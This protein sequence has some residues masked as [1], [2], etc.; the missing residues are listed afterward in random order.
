MFFSCN[1]ASWGYFF[2][3]LDSTMITLVHPCQIKLVSSYKDRKNE[4]Q[5]DETGIT[6]SIHPF[7]TCQKYVRFYIN[8][9]CNPKKLACN[10]LSS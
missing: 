5:L 2:Q 1:N 6:R 9:S 8:I 10:V 3:H 4:G 7:N